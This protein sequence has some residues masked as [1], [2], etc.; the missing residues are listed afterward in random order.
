MGGAIVARV[1]DVRQGGGAQDQR[2]QRKRVEAIRASEKGCD[3]KDLGEFSWNCFYSGLQTPI[4]QIIQKACMQLYAITEF[5]SE[6]CA[7]V[8]QWLPMQIDVLL[9]KSSALYPL[10][11]GI[12][13]TY[14]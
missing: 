1:E 6:Y 4:I 13:L 3:K 12:Q 14:R 9:K 8:L 7:V 5:L 11:S 2:Q 10:E